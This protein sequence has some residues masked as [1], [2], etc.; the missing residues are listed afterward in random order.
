MANVWSLISPYWHDAHDG[1]WIDAHVLWQPVGTVDPG[2]YMRARGRIKPFVTP[3]AIGVEG[4][5][6]QPESGAPED[7]HPLTLRIEQ[8]LP[9]FFMDRPTPQVNTMFTLTAQVGWGDIDS[10]EVKEQFSPGFDDGY[11]YSPVGFIWQ[12]EDTNRIRAVVALNRHFKAPVSQSA[13]VETRREGVATSAAG[14]YL[15]A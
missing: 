7:F 9:R 8:E 1:A 14:K 15:S 13:S 11:F 3:D 6:A 12:A 2:R 5:L 10:H 4:I